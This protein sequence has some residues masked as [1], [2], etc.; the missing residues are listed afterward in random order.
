MGECC[1]E[2]EIELYNTYPPNS[3]HE[4]VVIRR[5]DWDFEGYAVTVWFHLDG[6]AWVVLDTSRYSDDVEF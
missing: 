2:F 6:G 1:S 5:W 4:A 3:G